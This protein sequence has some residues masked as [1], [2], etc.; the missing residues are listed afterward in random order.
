MEIKRGVAVSPGVVIKRAFVLDS[1]EV[2]IPR[3][4]F[5]DSDADREIVRFT[6][7]LKATCDEIRATQSKIVA[8]VADSSVPDIFA[9]H[10]ALL[11]DE[12]LTADV[13]RLIQE[14]SY[15]AEYALSRALRPHLKRMQGLEDEYLRERTGDVRD[16]ERRLLRN[17]LGQRREELNSLTHEVV[18]IARDLSPSQT[19]NLDRTKV[20]GFATDGGGRTSHTAIVARALEIP[21]VVGL[22]DVTTEVSGGDWVIIDGNRG[23][24]VIAPDEETIKKYEG[25]EHNYHEIEVQWAEGRD[26]PATTL[27]GVPITLY[28]NIEFPEEVTLSLDRGASGIGLYRTEFLYLGAMRA[29]TEREHFDAYMRAIN[30]LG[31]RPLVIRTLD[32]GADKFPPEAGGV[33][34]KNPFLG[35]RSLRYCFQHPELLQT[36]LRA[37]LR[38][39]AFGKVRI[40]LPMVTTLQELRQA[41]EFIAEVKL[42]LDGEGVEYGRDIPLGIMIEVPSAAVIAG[43]FAKECDFFS[44]GTNDLIQYTLAVDRGNPR[45][46]ELYR[47]AHPAVLQ[48]LK[49]VLEVGRQSGIEVAMCGEMSGDVDYTMLLLGL[50]LRIFSVSPIMLSELKK[51]MRSVTIEQCVQVAEQAMTMDDPLYILGHLR[52]ETRKVIPEAYFD[53]D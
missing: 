42:E 19:A 15:S 18:V 13:T 46:A 3:R 37:I 11:E 34:E 27:D 41:K 5:V 10:L 25:R 49:Q 52:A 50:G 35:S 12:R 30:L 51:L 2:R 1:E 8:E 6:S 9:F 31:D 36:Q 21:A 47:P 32:L 44:I 7:A 24:V 53:E 45:V 40:L 43:A 16:V 26:L 4:H 22:G 20:R 17:L 29:P 23:L 38:A 39:S 28:G 33:V 48:L 14:R